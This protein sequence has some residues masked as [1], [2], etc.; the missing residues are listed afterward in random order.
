MQRALKQIDLHGVG[1][2]LLTNGKPKYKSTLGGIVTVGSRLAIFAYFLV[3]LKTVF[4]REQ[5]S[6][7]AV[8]EKMNFY[9]TT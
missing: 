8:K 5:V 4:L 2:N 6:V 7:T 1:V 3:L 9:D